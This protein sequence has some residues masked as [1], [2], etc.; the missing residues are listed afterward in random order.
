MKQNKYIVYVD[1]E[2]IRWKAVATLGHSSGMEALAKFR[3]DCFA[4]VTRDVEAFLNCQAPESTLLTST[5]IGTDGKRHHAV[6]IK[7]IP[8]DD[9]HRP[10]KLLKRVKILRKGISNRKS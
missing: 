2:W 3:N 4:K 9:S 1:E 8:T 10:G 6:E 5:F 7:R